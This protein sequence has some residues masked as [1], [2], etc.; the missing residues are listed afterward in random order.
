[1]GSG[2][3]YDEMT[4][5]ERMTAFAAGRE[6]DRIP[7]I[8][9]IGEHACRLIGVTVS[10]YNHSAELMAGAQIAAFRKYRPDSVGIGPG[11][12]GIA[13]AMGARL[14][15]PEDG[16]PYVSEPILKNYDDLNRLL[17]ADPH[18]DGRLPLYLEALKIIN[19]QIG[20]QVVVGSS[21]GGP[22]TTAASLRGTANFLRDLRKN[23]E[24]AHRL[25]QLVTVS[26][27]RY[28]DAVSDLGLK[29]S[30]SEPTA[31]GTLIS[32]EQFREFVKPYL[33]MYVD[34]IVERC[35]S[36]PMLHICGNT[37]RIWFDMADTG[38]TILSLDNE[39]DLAEAKEAVG[40]RVCLAGNVP[41]VETLMRGT[42]DQVL[43]KA[44]ECL[45]R[46][47]D[48]PKGYILSSGCALPLDTPPENVMALM[49]AARI[50]GKMPIDPERLV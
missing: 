17:P 45:R 1:M 25:L 3:G 37:S 41:P 18:R 30:I 50:Y 40:D 16:M 22:F 27:L 2:I 13:E 6:I 12:F 48:N 28:I 49:E 33:K 5:K 43:A 29:P 34:R 38:A 21:V 44:K 19:K 7:C 42:R 26:A 15:F 4:P 46:A 23:P 36:G 9:L 31:S 47:H 8:P 14:N 20:D 24:M 10:R 32:A 35:G 11:L 39:I